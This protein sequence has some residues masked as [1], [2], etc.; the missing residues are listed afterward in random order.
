MIPMSEQDDRPSF[1]LNG[2]RYTHNPCDD[3][4]WEWDA[5]D[6]ATGKIVGLFPESQPLLKEIARLRVGGYRAR[7]RTHGGRA[8]R[9]VVR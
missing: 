6:I 2:I 5:A 3:P 9:P 1:D 7:Q 4:V 8:R